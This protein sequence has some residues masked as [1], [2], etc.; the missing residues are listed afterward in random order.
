MYGL[1]VLEVPKSLGQEIESRHRCRLMTMLQ[2]AAVRLHDSVVRLQITDDDICD[3]VTN[4]VEHV[5]KPSALP[6]PYSDRVR[7]QN[8]SLLL[9]H[10]P[11]RST[12]SFG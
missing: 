11:L 8:H 6:L 4:D 9:E 7:M 12:L 5:V 10:D 3:M 2:R 1:E